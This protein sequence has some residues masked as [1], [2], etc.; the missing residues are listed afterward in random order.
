MLPSDRGTGRSSRRSRS[1]RGAGPVERPGVIVRGLKDK[2][3]LITGGTSG[4]GKAAARRFLEEGSRAFVCGLEQDELEGTRKELSGL[5]AVDGM[6]CDVSREGDVAE[7]VARADGHLGRI[8]VLINNAGIAQREGFLDI[9]TDSWD[10]VL[11]VN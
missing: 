11:S 9:T 7:L 8:D 10:R 6:T 3:V 2:G 4:I 1:R 5:G